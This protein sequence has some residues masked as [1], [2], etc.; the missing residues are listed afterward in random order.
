MYTDIRRRTQPSGLTLSVYLCGNCRDIASPCDIITTSYLIPT[1]HL[2]HHDQVHEL[3]R[4]VLYS[5]YILGIQRVNI[6]E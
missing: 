3:E 6:Q 2:A 1:C 4:N 5:F